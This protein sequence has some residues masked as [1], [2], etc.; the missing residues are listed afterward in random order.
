MKA[1]LIFIAIY[2]AQILVVLA[3]PYYR[4]RRDVKEERTIGDFMSYMKEEAMEPLKF[5]AFFP[6]LGIIVLIAISILAVL[7]ISIE[8]IYRNFIKNIKI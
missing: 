1:Y 2:I 4:Y 7:I 8:W 6:Y 3:Y 5:C